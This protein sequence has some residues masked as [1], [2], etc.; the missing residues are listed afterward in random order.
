MSSFHIKDRQVAKHAQL[1]MNAQISSLI[2]SCA[3]KAFTLI[4]E[5]EYVQYARLDPLANLQLYLLRLVA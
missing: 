5:M 4:W 2:Q 3:L 1:D